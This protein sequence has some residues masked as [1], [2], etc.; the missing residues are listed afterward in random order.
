MI[1]NPTFMPDRVIEQRA[2]QMLSGFESRF[3]KIA[4]PPVP[5]DKLIE[6]HLDL[7]IEWCDIA[8]TD[9]EK[10]LGYLK[11]DE[12]K[13]YMNALRRDH[14]EE[15]IGTEAY[16]KA[17]E[18]G[19]WD[20]HVIKSGETQL[21]LPFFAPPQTFLCRG[22][23]KDSREIQAERYAAYLLMPHHLV[24]SEIAGLDLTRWRTLY[25]LKDKFGVTITALKNR[26]VGLKLIYISQDG[27]IFHSEEESTGMQLM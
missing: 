16:T 9:D 5:I 22:D 11:P 1:T 4:S 13:I 12:K 7:W 23:K 19:H 21:Q 18:V 26:L 17:H 10:I 14:F 24:I 27:K 3:G 20:M 25:E 15:Y 6:R 8:D 2:H